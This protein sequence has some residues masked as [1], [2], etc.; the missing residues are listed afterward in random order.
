MKLDGKVAIVTGAASGIGQAIAT[1]MASE[2]AS[3]V[4]DYVGGPDGANQ[5][6]Q[7]ITGGGRQG[8][9]FRGRRLAAG[10]GQ[11]A[12]PAGRHDLR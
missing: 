1:I 9:R 12:H 6:V 10:P 8:R 11:C 7:A 4:I 2:G 5:T 3:V